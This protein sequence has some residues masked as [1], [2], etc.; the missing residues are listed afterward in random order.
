MNGGADQSASPNPMLQCKSPFLARLGTFSAPHQIRQLSKVQETRYPSTGRVYSMSVLD[1]MQTRHDDAQEPGY[2]ARPSG[3]THALPT[4]RTILKTAKALGRE[5][6]AA[7]LGEPPSLRLPVMRSV[8]AAGLE[9][10]PSV[11]RRAREKYAGHT[12]GTRP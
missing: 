2:V 7:L 3:L 10:G 9:A 6:S 12:L 1:P 4:N 11:S 5:V 8:E